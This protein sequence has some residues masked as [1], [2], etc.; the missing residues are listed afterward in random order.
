MQLLFRR[1]AALQ[2]SEFF[3]FD[4][5]SMYPTGLAA[6]F[7]GGIG[8]DNLCC[9]YICDANDNYFFRGMDYSTLDRI[10]FTRTIAK[11]IHDGGGSP[12]GGVYVDFSNPEA[13]AAM[14]EVY[15][16][17]VEL[18]KEVF[19]IDVA[20]TKLECALEAYE[21]GSNPRVDEKLMVEGLPGLFL[22]SRWRSIRSAR[23]FIGERCLSRRLIRMMQAVEYAE[24]AGKDKPK[25]FTFD[26]VE[27]EINRLHEIRIRQTMVRGLRKL[28]V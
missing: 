5:I 22:R 7:V 27:E 18:W 8:A 3:Q 16:R 21:H 20:S 24:G 6:T 19:G 23:R 9:E 10:T 15:R 26:T 2:D 25:A 12:N 28:P 4:L 13:F 17:N 11:A 1:G 14:G